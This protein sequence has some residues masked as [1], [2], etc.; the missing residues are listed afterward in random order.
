[1]KSLGSFT[2]EDV[3]QFRD[4]VVL[5][6]AHALQAI[7]GKPLKDCIDQVADDET[8]QASVLLDMV[9]F[10]RKYSDVNEL[11]R[12]KREQY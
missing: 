7:S 5:R 4:D 1:M 11:R 2:G 9:A 12:S 10:I 8:H 3:L 6:E